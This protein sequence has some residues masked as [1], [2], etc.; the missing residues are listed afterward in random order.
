LGWEMR[1]APDGTRTRTPKSVKARNE[2]D[3]E[4]Y[5][6]ASCAPMHLAGQELPRQGPKSDGRFRGNTPVV[7]SSN[8]S[9][10]DLKA[11]SASVTEALKLAAHLMIQL[12]RRL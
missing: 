4:A 5:A 12:D 8:A 1:G 7:L 9:A 6:I 2:K 10:C 3:L 11:K